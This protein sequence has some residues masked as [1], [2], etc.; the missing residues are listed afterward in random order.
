ML[1]RFLVL[2]V[3]LLLVDGCAATTS[4]QSTV[5][6]DTVA[7]Y[8]KISRATVLIRSTYL[9]HNHSSD[10]RPGNG[11]G[12]GIVVDKN[13]YILTAAH[14]VHGA[15]KVVVSFADTSS[16]AADVVGVDPLSDL[17]VLKINL[18][19]GHF[20]TVE[21][22]DSDLIQIGERVLAIGHPFGL[23]YALTNGV[24]SGFGTQPGIF[25]ERVIQTSAPINPGN[26]GGPLIDATGHVVGINI[27][28]LVGAQNIGFAIPINTAAEV[29]V[30]LKSRGRVIRP[31]LGIAGKMVTQEIQHLFAL[32][33]SAGFIVEDIAPGSPAEK[34]AL[35]GGALNI[36]VD[37]EPWI[38]GGDIIRSING[39]DIRVAEALTSNL[40]AMK[41]GQNV[42]LEIL[43]E[44]KSQM[45]DIT[46]QERPQLPSHDTEQQHDVIQ[47][48]PMHKHVDMHFSKDDE[49]HL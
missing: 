35:R 13:G 8:K 6:D 48:R 45:I 33:L 38:L 17:A 18:S 37:G 28:M 47:V 34:A 40:K 16:M 31:W 41:V 24:V 27:A 9:N 20:P 19:T 1:S 7:I 15:A 25:H 36:T 44:G 22:G 29:L 5:K 21:F 39:H 32:P 4:A 12:C 10:G 49:M 23:G 43:R 2:V 14:L 46:L 3:V 30:E 26:S 42:T 11:M